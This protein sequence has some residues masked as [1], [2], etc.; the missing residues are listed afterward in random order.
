MR[1]SLSARRVLAL[2]VALLGA[3]AG[4]VAAAQPL[5]AQQ[6]ALAA[7]YTNNDPQWAL[8]AKTG[9]KE[10]RAKGLLTATFPPSV[11]ALNGR[12]FRISGFISPL[13]S[14]SS[15][16]H[17]IVTRRS[18]T[19]PFCPPNAPT[20][21]VEVKLDAPTRQTDEEIV[22][23]GRLSLVSAS[24]EGLFYVLSGAKVE[25]AHRG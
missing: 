19:C 17:F 6:Q 25:P 18:T 14:S 4:G 9:V 7:H 16:R 23:L 2:A 1:V 20:E 5:T 10:D 15:T 3:G 12:T 24:D 11:Q 21:A 13:E 22:V 8:L